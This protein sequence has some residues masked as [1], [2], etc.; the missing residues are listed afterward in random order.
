MGLSKKLFVVDGQWTVIEQVVGVGFQYYHRHFIEDLVQ[1][2]VEGFD[3]KPW[4]R[5]K[6]K[7]YCFSVLIGALGMSVNESMG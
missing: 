5:T 4:S 6:V 7:F 3:P 1:L 2:D